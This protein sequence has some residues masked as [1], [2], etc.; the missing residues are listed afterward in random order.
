MFP[1][2]KDLEKTSDS[3]LSVMLY[4]SEDLAWF[5]GHFDSQPILPGVAQ[6]DWVMRYA[7]QYLVPDAQFSSLD[8]VKFINPILPQRDVQIDIEWHE[9]K[10]QLVFHYYLMDAEHRT[11]SSGKIRLC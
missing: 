11:L 6:I 4:I 8:Q 5:E 2:E 3:S 1:I 7:T 9:S 10:K